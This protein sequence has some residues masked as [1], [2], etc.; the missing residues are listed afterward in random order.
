MDLRKKTPVGTLYANYEWPKIEQNGFLITLCDK[1]KEYHTICRVC[2]NDSGN[3]Q[4]HVFKNGNGKSIP[5]VIDIIPEK[6]GENL[7]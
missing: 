1:D 7:C 3:L 5:T 6:R 2:V 4:V